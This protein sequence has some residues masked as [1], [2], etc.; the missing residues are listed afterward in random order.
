VKVLREDCEV[1]VVWSPLASSVQ[2]LADRVSVKGTYMGEG[3]TEK[4]TGFPLRTHLRCDN[5]MFNIANKIAYGNQM[6]KG[7]KDK[8][9]DCV[10]GNSCWFNVEGRELIGKHGLREE[11]DVLMLKLQ[12]L[13]AS[14]YDK[15][16]YVIS[17]FVTVKFACEDM[18]KNIRI[19]GVKSHVKCGTIHTFQGQE[20]E[21]VFLLL[22]SN[23]AKDGAREWVTESPNM[24]NVALT[25]AKKRF[26][27]IGNKKLWGR[28]KYINQFG[29]LLPAVD[30]NLE[31]LRNNTGLFFNQSRS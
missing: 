10:L 5:P 25:R 12:L 21:I 29:D 17:P 18:I 14:G 7:L 1:D 22:G 31:E 4:W 6:V 26:Y 11:L 23:P 28:K 15:D 30:V 9:F 20:A 3:E 2:A 24:I 19:T 27:M 16:V 8:P 13:F